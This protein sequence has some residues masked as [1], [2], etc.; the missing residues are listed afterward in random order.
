[1]TPKHVEEILLYHNMRGFHNDLKDIEGRIAEVK[2][3]PFQVITAIQYTFT[4]PANHN[5][6]S[7]V[8]I[9][10]IHNVNMLILEQQRNELERFIE[11][12]ER[13]INGLTEL[14]RKIITMRYMNRYNTVTYF[15]TVAMNLNI[16]EITCKRLTYKALSKIATMLSGCKISWEVDN[17]NCDFSHDSLQQQQTSGQ[18]LARS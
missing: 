7:P 10:V 5:I 1:M 15:Y 18:T 9:A 13:A 8:E 11:R 2:S 3:S 6:V 4:K 14:E 16:S 17:E 12:L